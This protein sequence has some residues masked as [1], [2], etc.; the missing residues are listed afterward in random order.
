MRMTPRMHIG[1]SV[2]DIAAPGW[3]LNTTEIDDQWRRA[4]QWRGGV[5]EYLGEI[6]EASG[7]RE[8]FSGI[9]RGEIISVLG[10]LPNS[11]IGW[12]LKKSKRKNHVSRP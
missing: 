1:R 9:Q 6:A 12:F 2:T 5:W 4:G 7:Q 11:S 10:R 3:L 8:I